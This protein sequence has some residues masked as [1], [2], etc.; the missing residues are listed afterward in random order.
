MPREL[1]EWRRTVKNTWI[2]IKNE[3]YKVKYYELCNKN[4][5]YF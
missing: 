4:R 2:L 5:Q 3:E 1:G